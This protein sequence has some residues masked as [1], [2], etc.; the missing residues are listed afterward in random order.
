MDQRFEEVKKRKWWSWLCR[1]RSLTP[2]IN[3]DEELDDIN[4]DCTFWVGDFYS[5]QFMSF[6]EILGRRSFAFP[7]LAKLGS[8]RALVSQEH[9]NDP[10]RA[11]DSD[12]GFDS[13]W[14]VD[15]KLTLLADD[16]AGKPRQSPCQFKLDEDRRLA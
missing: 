15:L 14:T 7:L 1:F 6:L 3:D 12:A 4:L 16:L 9:V 8:A 11:F 5:V 2:S 10:S 13:T